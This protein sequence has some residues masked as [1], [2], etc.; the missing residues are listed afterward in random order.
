MRNIMVITLAAGALAALSASSALAVPI[1]GSAMQD[2]VQATSSVQQARLYCYDRN[3]GEFLHWG[4]CDRPRVYCR[5]HERYS[6]RY[7]FLHWGA[8]D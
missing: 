5:H 6:S 8:C 4:P 2:A 1:S 7:R 3:T